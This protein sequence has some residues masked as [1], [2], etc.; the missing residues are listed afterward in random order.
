[1][2]NGTSQVSSH[3]Q[4]MQACI[5]SWDTCIGIIGTPAIDSPSLI[6]LSDQIPLFFDAIVGKL[7]IQYRL[8]K[9]RFDTDHAF[10]PQSHAYIATLLFHL[11]DALI[12]MQNHMQQHDIDA[13]MHL[14]DKIYQLLT[15]TQVSPG[16][17]QPID[18]H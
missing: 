17:S 12:Q 8:C 15:T 2:T 7:Y 4:L 9:Q 18:I 10:P 5:K 11:Y 16:M 14:L 6:D 13:G 3:Q 1:M